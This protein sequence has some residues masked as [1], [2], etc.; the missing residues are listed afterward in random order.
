MW[1]VIQVMTGDEEKIALLCRRMIGMED[2]EDGVLQ[3]C[4]IPYT[5]RQRRYQGK[6]HTEQR[7]LFPGYVFLVSGQ[8]EE[9]F[10][11]LR[12]VPGLT[13]ILG[14]GWEFVPLSEEEVDLLQRLGGEDRIVEISTGVIENEQIIIKSGPL[15][16]M[17]GYIKKIDRHKRIARL[18]VE[19][20]GRVME[21]QVG[22]EVVEKLKV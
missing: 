6:W 19:M 7:T 15:K 14:T 10:F 8:P 13:K 3:S 18:E 22:L 16:G 5:K 12:H 9:L 2:G 11:Q 17:E 20:M 21:I 4:F 1:Y